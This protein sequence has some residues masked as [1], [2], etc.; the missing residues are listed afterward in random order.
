MKKVILLFLLLILITGA[1]TPFSCNSITISGIVTDN[2]NPIQGA[3]VGIK[4]VSY[5]WGPDELNYEDYISTT[6]TDV[7]GQYSLI[8]VPYGEYEL[9]AEYG[10]IISVPTLVQTSYIS[11]GI[12]CAEVN[13]NI[14][15]STWGE[16]LGG[17]ATEGGISNNLY[18]SYSP[19][20]AINNSG[21]PVVV[22][23][24]HGHIYLK[25]WNGTSWEELGGSATGNGI[26]NNPSFSESPSLAI[27][28]SGNPVVAWNCNYHI[29]LKQWNGTSWEQLGGS[30]TGSGI[31]NGSYESRNPSLSINNS[32]NP[33][34]AWVYNYNYSYSYL[35]QWN[36][37][38]WEELG[39][40]ASD[41]G[42]GYG[43]SPSLAINNS[44][45]PV[46]A[47]DYWG[48]I[49]LKQWNGASWE[50]LGGSAYNNGIGSGHSPSLA[51]NNSDNPV[52]AWY[53]N[54]N[55][56]LKQWNDTRWEVLGDSTTEG[57]IS[58]SP[59][60]SNCYYPSLAINNSG[61]PV[62]AWSC[63]N[64]NYN[65][66]KIYLK[67]WNGTY[68]EELGGSA[69]GYGI[70]NNSHYPIVKINSSDML[71]IVYVFNDYNV[72]LKEWNK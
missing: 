17:S 13:E 26:D 58:S 25:Q 32:G 12:S 22:W 46:V 45:N 30:A 11:N 66:I 6:T 4:P 20:L 53:D 5:F 23:S 35:K 47:W 36:G 10:Q 48:D 51:I 69:T 7:N 24:N 27:N 28:N 44:G 3:I 40:S 64:N 42:I 52:V 19:S 61:N 70:S 56:Y 15:L 60:G 65:T 31:S 9:Y 8:N 54:N 71:F 18:Y 38:T 21:N 14:K 29:Y 16:E 37:L 59:Y 55:I 68:W 50:K 72:Y 67:Q 39:S 43:Y 41:V 2:D 34:V 33:V 49:Y 57:V 62:V 63:Y 1:F